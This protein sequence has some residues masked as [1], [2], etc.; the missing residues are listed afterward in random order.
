MEYKLGA[1]SIIIDFYMIAFIFT[2][3][4]CCSA[5]LYINKV[6]FFGERKLIK[7]YL[8]PDQAF[9]IDF[10]LILVNGF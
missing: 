2:F 9:S 5:K 6:V 10:Y 7:S 8:G 1:L 3:F 4:F